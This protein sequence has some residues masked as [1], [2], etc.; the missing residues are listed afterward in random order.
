MDRQGNQFETTLANHLDLNLELTME[1][2][3]ITLI[4][5]E[6]KLRTHHALVIGKWLAEPRQISQRH[7]AFKR[8]TTISQFA[9]I[10]M[11][12]NRCI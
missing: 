10:N 12:W 7:L 11:R 2:H 6:E 4:T 1:N 9:R 3:S 5:L 8:G